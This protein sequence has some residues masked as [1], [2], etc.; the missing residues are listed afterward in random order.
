[1]SIVGIV[2]E[3]Y[4]TQ[5]AWQKADREYDLLC[6]DRSAIEPHEQDRHPKPLDVLI[7][8]VRDSLE[9]Q[10]AN[11]SDQAKAWMELLIESDAPLLRRLAVHT[12]SQHAGISP[13]EKLSWLLAR[14]GLHDISAHHEIYRA[15]QSAYQG[16]NDITRKAIIEAIMAY[17]WP[18]PNADDVAMHTTRVQFDWLHWIHT[19]D[20]TCPL[21][22]KALEKVLTQYPEWKPGKYPDLLSWMESGPAVPPPSP[23]KVNDLL[24]K[25]ATEWLAAFLDFRGNEFDGPSRGSG[26]MAIAEASRQNFV[27]GMDL[28]RALAD[29]AH[30]NSD[31]W[32][33]VLSAWREA[34][35]NEEDWKEILESL[36]QDHL[37]E[38][39][40]RDVAS[41]L[42]ALVS[43]KEQPFAAS[44]LPE[45]NE[46]AWS[47]WGKL[48][49]DKALAN[50]DDWLFQ[51]IN[52]PAGTLLLFWLRSLSVRI[53]QEGKIPSKLPSEFQEWFSAVVQ[54]RTI[55]G[56]LGR[57][58]LAN[59]LD[60]LL[61]V[62]REWTQLHLVPLF[63]SE[64]AEG[65][66]VQVWHGFLGS[67]GSSPVVFETLE[68]AFL[69]ALSHLE[70]LGTKRERY[71]EWFVALLVFY[72]DNPLEKWIPALFEKGTPEDVR[73]FTMAVGRHLWDLE[74][75]ACRTLWTRWLKQYWENRNRGIPRTLD[76]AEAQQ[77]LEWVTRLKPVFPEAVTL[78]IEGT[79]PDYNRSLVLHEINRKGIITEYPDATAR[80]I[81]HLCKSELPSYFRSELKELGDS[82]AETLADRV[83]LHEL[84]EC[85]A[86][87][88]C[89]VDRL[90]DR[91]DS[92]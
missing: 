21:A 20:P 49:R 87:K 26:L 25:S 50:E 61:S 86:T 64:T 14:V 40:Q 37:L 51:A 18:H 74:E 91:L 39:Q 12:L 41:L 15:V 73:R 46:V 83:L 23:W 84:C 36:R 11:N 1:V 35:L 44:L 42:Y 13:D 85:L 79:V 4:Q 59:A 77:M 65:A 3:I 16:L 10:A 8:A 88:G 75:G 7:D 9:W 52:H 82:L 34:E 29:G 32:P 90:R 27:W 22:K 53:R 72:V 71:M 60:F 69:E 68:P 48:N 67:S 33:P 57:V 47:L 78:F 24:A 70:G 38:H 30:W 45:A 81:I 28:F 92:L 43:G 17:R 89:N 62:D 31:L 66:Y 54:D 58:V 6:A 76:P 63:H 80:L 5:H 19:A 2:Q 55:V 56:K